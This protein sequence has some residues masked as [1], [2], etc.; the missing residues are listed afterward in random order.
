[1]GLSVIFPLV[2]C[3]LYLLPHYYAHTL[4]TGFKWLWLHPSMSSFRHTNLKLGIYSQAF[5]LLFP[6]VW[7]KS[8]PLSPATYILNPPVEG[9]FCEIGRISVEY[10]TPF[11]GVIHFFLGQAGHFNISACGRAAFHLNPATYPAPFP[12]SFP[13]GDWYSLP[14]GYMGLTI[15]TLPPGQD[16]DHYCLPPQGDWDSSPTASPLLWRPSTCQVR[17]C[18]LITD[19]KSLLGGRWI[20]WLHTHLLRLSRHWRH[21]ILLALFKPADEILYIWETRYAA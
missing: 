15:A 19:D 13:T 11:F 10:Q 20:T 21:S 9:H 7:I 1:M 16:R 5:R 12:E 6:R 4:Y 18:V 2:F 17:V 3:F 8:A 14:G